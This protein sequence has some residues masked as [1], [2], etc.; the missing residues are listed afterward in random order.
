MNKGQGRFKAVLTM[1][2]MQRACFDDFSTRGK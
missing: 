2:A 1:N